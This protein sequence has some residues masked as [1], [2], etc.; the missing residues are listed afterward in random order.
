MIGT[1]DVK[2]NSAN[3]NIP[4]KTLFAYINSPS[5]IRVIDVPKKIGK[6]NITE[7]YFT[8]N[9]PDNTIVTS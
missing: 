3:P 4:L 9:Y 5:S 1:I 2:I 6:W 7:V 8:A